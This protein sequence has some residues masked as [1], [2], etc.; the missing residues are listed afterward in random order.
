[1]IF[2]DDFDAVIMLTW[3]DWKSEPRS[4]RYHYATRF[5]THVPV[6]FLQHHSLVEELVVEPSGKE[7]LDIINVSANISADEVI[8]FL[9]LLKIRG[10]TRPLVWIYDTLNYQLLLDSLPTAFR[11][12]HATEDYFTKSNDWSVAGASN[13]DLIAKS[14]V[15]T[16]EQVDYMVACS[17][18]VCKSYLTMGNYCGRYAVIEN[19]C[20]AE[21][22]FGFLGQTEN[23]DSRNT[24]PIALFQGGINSRLD[25]GLLNT[26]VKSMPDWEFWF[27]GIS[28]ESEAWTDLRAHQNVKYLG[29]LEPDELAQVMCKATAGIITFI[30]DQLIRNSLPLKAFEYVACGLPVITVPITALAGHPEIITTA[31]TPLE[32]KNAL[33]TAKEKRFDHNLLKR[34]R[35]I[36]LSRSYNVLFKNMCLKLKKAVAHK[37]KEKK[38]LRVAILYDSVRS[39]HVD[40]IKSHLEAFGQY[41]SHT[42]TY[43][44]ATASFWNLPPERTPQFVDFA[45]FDVVV[46]HYS[47]RL[48]VWDHLDQGIA[49]SL[50]SFNGFKVLFVQDEYEGTEITRQWM[51]RL[52]FNL[53]YTCIPEDDR[54]LVYPSYRYPSTIFLTTLTGYVP[55]TTVIEQFA[56][57]LSDR[58]CLIAYRGRA[59]PKIYG[60]L[61]QEKY[62]IGVEMKRI[63][64]EFDVQVDIEVDDSKRIYGTD[65][66]RFLGSSRATLGT[67]SGAN[68]FDFDGSLQAAIARLEL[69]NPNITYEEVSTKLL[70]PHEGVVKMNQISPKIF[71]AILMRTALVLFEGHYSN[72]II[73]NKHFFPLKKDFSNAGEIIVQLQDDSLVQKMTDRAY[74]DIILSGKYSYQS[75]IRL[76]DDNLDQ[77]ILRE[78]QLQRL[79]G[80]VFFAGSGKKPRKALP[81]MPKDILPVR[82]D[83]HWTLLDFTDEHLIPQA[84]LA[85]H[86]TQ[87]FFYHAA[88]FLYRLIPS[89]VRQRLS[90]ILKSALGQ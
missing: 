27:C 57:P 28:V 43:V 44:P 1:M 39:L 75:F 30:Q 84:H 41:S 10:I 59:L 62:L 16:L 47:V 25:Y 22:F 67:E 8:E 70:S 48:S 82:E 9:R 4:N 51:D 74:Q 66:F 68:I 19:G 50:E 34:R 77:R 90:P 64:A 81:M 6:L 65:W 73:A 45:F 15:K 76:F 13:S 42:I 36:A 17:D 83:G 24:A 23:N 60:D 29:V 35:E 12:Y 85:K 3:S 40:T 31:S 14:C 54:E 5:A 86:H 71:E 46:V 69:K 88:L 49:S 58:K 38:N 26:L 37:K 61:G 72:V 33:L 63:A 78:N 52:Q 18:S 89:A 32:F 80:P 56:K 11:V 87:P 55:A 2:L 79:N 53:V 20:D 7:N 21:F